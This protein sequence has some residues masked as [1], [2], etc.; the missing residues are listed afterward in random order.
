L[1]IF[2]P[3]CTRFFICIWMKLSVKTATGINANPYHRVPT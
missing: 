2:T 1:P 3:S